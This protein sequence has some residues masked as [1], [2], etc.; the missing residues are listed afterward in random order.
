MHWAT[1]YIGLPW[2]RC[3]DNVTCFNCWSFTRLIQL[4]HYNRSLPDIDI[5]ALSNI[6]IAKLCISQSKS[7]NWIEV[8]KPID[9]SCALLC[10]NKIPIHVGTWL[11]TSNM[12]G[13]LHCMTGMGVMFQDLHSLR[14]SGWSKLHYFNWDANA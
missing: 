1:Q 9:G 7:N 11:E 3:G 8:P 6:S 2:H 12:R 5:D 13:L 4:K 14:A 10:R